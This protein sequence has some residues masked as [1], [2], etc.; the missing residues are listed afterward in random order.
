MAKNGSVGRVT[1]RFGRRAAVGFVLLAMAV[2]SL[3]GLAPTVAADEAMMVELNPATRQQL[4]TLRE[5]W[6]GWS[7]AFAKDDQATAEASL[8]Q[9]GAIARHLG[10][11][12]LPDFSIAIA[13]YA[14][15][16]AREGKIERSRWALEHSRRLDPGRPESDYALATIQRLSG[17]YI[18]ALLASIRGY[19]GLLKLPTERSIWLHNVG[20]WC[21]YLLL[22]SSAAFLAL[23][24]AVKGKRLYYDLVRMVSPPVPPLVA[25]ALVI[26]L[27][28]WP[29]ALPAGP[30]WLAL[31][32]SILL[33]GYG[34]VSEKVV[35]GALWLVFGLMPLVLAQQQL[36]IQL[37]LIPPA[38]A[39][40]Q[41]ENKR[42]YGGMFTDL[43]VLQVLLPDSVGVRELVADLHRQMGQW[44]QARSIYNF[45]SENPDLR[46]QQVAPSLSNLGLYHLREEEFDTATDYFI[47]AAEAD[48]G[49]A[50]AYFN[51]NL[52]Y[53]GVYD[54][55]N[56]HNAM[57]QA[58][59]LAPE[60]IDAWT[61][62]D[63]ATAK[64]IGI[65]VNGGLDQSG[66]ILQSLR[67]LW[68]S[69][70]STSWTDLWRRHFSLTIVFSTFLLALTLHMARL[71]MGY[72]S[73]RLEDEGRDSVNRWQR[74]FV[75]GLASALEGKG[76]N[77]FLGILLP[78]G[79]LMLPLLRGVGYRE[80]LGFDPG[81]W[82]PMV[83]G[84]TALTLWLIARIA[85]ELSSDR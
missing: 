79:L 11:E 77:A 23:Q 59:A 33:W 52:A 76:P 68:R 17:D 53:S 7:D 44:D 71:Q 32:W 28:L 74:V 24:M 72:R 9:M 37:K 12:R 83:T 58:R 73:S 5:A 67:G 16:S 29:L 14:V 62:K 63:S 26:V 3:G 41:L 43:G 22:L 78:M 46:A 64:D 55:D 45:L 18:G 38:R 2:G 57:E 25:D 35:F 75:P 69:E 61:S 40:E 13:S 20:L 66:E 48:P 47:R 21:V 51:L 65:P 84:I 8:E 34:S 54:F 27:L 39:L 50:E 1:G 49:L 81:H 80:P 31:Y 30:L 4:R 10:M 19:V 85:W 60:S 6:Q 56:S 36:S 82:L 15:S 70:K 42:L